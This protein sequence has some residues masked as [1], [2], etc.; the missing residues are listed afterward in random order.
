M[1][2]EL[3]PEEVSKDRYFK[4]IAEISEEMIDEHGKDFA[5]GAL[6]MAAQWIARDTSKTAPENQH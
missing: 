4:R 1:K 5:M 2:N 6:V 3:T